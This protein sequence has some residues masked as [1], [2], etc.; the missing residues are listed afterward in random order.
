TRPAVRPAEA[1]MYGVD[2][3]S[4]SERMRN[5]LRPLIRA[6]YGSTS[7]H[8]PYGLIASGLQVAMDDAAAGRGV[9]RVEDLDA[10]LQLAID[11]HWTAERTAVH[12]LHDE[13]VGAEVVDLADVRMVERG[14]RA[15]LALHA[16]REPPGARFQRDGTVQPRVPRPVDDAHAAF[17]DRAVDFVRSQPEPGVRVIAAA[18]YSLRLADEIRGVVRIACAFVHGDLRIRAER[19][20]HVHAIDVHVIRRDVIRCLTALTPVLQ[21]GESGKLIRTRS[22]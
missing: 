2:V 16:I 22:A 20:A 15:R 18:L 6:L 3:P 4:R 11:R 1:W 19:A 8:H 17:A 10:E 21:G 12:E 13:E 9:E 14:D 5:S 7:A